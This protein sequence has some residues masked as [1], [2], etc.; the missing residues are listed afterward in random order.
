MQVV[1]EYVLLFAIGSVCGCVL[2]YFL[3][4]KEIK[5][6]ELS[7]KEKQEQ[8]DLL[9]EE[10]T[11]LSVEIA[12]FSEQQKAWATYNISCSVMEPASR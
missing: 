1:M 3:K 6:F 5:R 12:K 9:Q 4:Y 10:R 7:E 11:K 8:I 2:V